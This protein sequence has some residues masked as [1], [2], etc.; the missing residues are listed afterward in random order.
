MGARGRSS[1]RSGDPAN[2]QVMIKLNGQV[3]IKL[4]G[5]MTIQPNGQ[6]MIRLIQPLR[7]R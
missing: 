6:G 1:G 3:M 4:N 2:G 5:Q 7:S